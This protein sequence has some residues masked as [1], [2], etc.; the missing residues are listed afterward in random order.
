[1]NMIFSGNIG[2]NPLNPHQ[3][4][5]GFFYLPCFQPNLRQLVGALSALCGGGNGG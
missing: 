4:T 3:Q 2:K 5:Q 1:M